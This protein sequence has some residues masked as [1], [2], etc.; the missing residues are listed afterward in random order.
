VID[1]QNVQIAGPRVRNVAIARISTRPARISASTRDRIQEVASH[2]GYVPNWLARGLRR[3]RSGIVGFIGDEVATTPYAVRMI[4][5]AQEA[6]REAGLL[7]VLMNSQ[8]DPALTARE[9]R[10]AGCLLA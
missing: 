6:L 2:F 8:G 9:M 10:D 5:G 1:V 7:M 4:L 3:Q